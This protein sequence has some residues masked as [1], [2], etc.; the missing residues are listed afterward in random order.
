MISSSRRDRGAA[1]VSAVSHS[2]GP[3]PRR[4]RFAKVTRVH[5]KGISVL[6]IAAQL[7]LTSGRVTGARIAYGAHGPDATA[8]QSRG[9]RARRPHARCRRHRSGTGGRRRRH[10]AG[11]RRHRQR[12]VATRNS[13]HPF[14]PTAARRERKHEAADENPASSFVSTARTS[15]LSSK[16]APICSTRCANRSAICRSKAAAG[17]ARAAPA[18]C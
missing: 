9:A 3:P 6:S 18:R 17:R 8:R 16:A 13:S 2:S 4:F 10:L 7:P 12:L 14:A 5:P 15:P 11:R 1:L